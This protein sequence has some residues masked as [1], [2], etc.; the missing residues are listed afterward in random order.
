MVSSLIGLLFLIDQ[1][2]FGACRTGHNIGCINR[3]IGTGSE[4]DADFVQTTLRDVCGKGNLP[5]PFI[6]IS[7]MLIALPDIRSTGRA[8]F[9]AQAAFCIAIIDDDTFQRTGTDGRFPAGSIPDKYLFVG[10]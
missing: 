10:E 3:T 1:D 8:A 6:G 9:P 7:I 4:V 5:L 2:L